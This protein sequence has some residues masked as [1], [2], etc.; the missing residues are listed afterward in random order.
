MRR[1]VGA[2]ESPNGVVLVT[3]ADAY[4]EVDPW[5][6]PTVGDVWRFV[7]YIPFA[8]SFLGGFETGAGRA[9]LL[10]VPAVVLVLTAVVEIRSRR[11]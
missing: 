9:F 6:L 11:G 4:P 5:R 1:V 7:F 2:E 10:I 8:G 3:K